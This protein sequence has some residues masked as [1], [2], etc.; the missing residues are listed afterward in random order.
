M[1]EL[2]Q[3]L[4]NGLRGDAKAPAF[5]TPNLSLRKDLL[6]PGSLFLLGQ[7]LQLN[8]HFSH[9]HPCCKLPSN[10]TVDIPSGD[11]AAIWQCHDLV[12][13]KIAQSPINPPHSW[14]AQQP[15]NLPGRGTYKGHINPRAAPRLGPAEHYGKIELEEVMLLKGGQGELL[16]GAGKEGSRTYL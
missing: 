15:L 13:P 3:S 4:I 1:P 11:N 5:G 9:L 6:T 16:K 8:L 2:T 14:R 7:Q 10:T 12:M